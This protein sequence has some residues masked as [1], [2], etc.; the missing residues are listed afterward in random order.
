M[1]M[2]REMYLSDICIFSHPDTYRKQLP[3]A[4]RRRRI[5]DY[6]E[7]YYMVAVRADEYPAPDTD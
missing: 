3:C 2:K 5:S 6:S 7:K 1:D 4:I